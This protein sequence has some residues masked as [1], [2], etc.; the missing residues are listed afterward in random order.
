MHKKKIN[1]SNAPSV[2]LQSLD[3]TDPKIYVDFHKSLNKDFLI[4]PKLKT[5]LELSSQ[6]ILSLFPPVFFQSSNKYYLIARY[7][8]YSL[9][10]LERKYK[11]AAVIIDN[12]K[13]IPAVQQYEHIDKQ[14]LKK[15]SDLLNCAPTTTADTESKKNNTYRSRKSSSIAKSIKKGRICPYHKNDIFHVLTTP[16]K[17][18]LPDKNGLIA[19]QCINRSK[20][21]DFIGLVTPYELNLLEKYK[22][23]TNK[24]IE[25]VKD[26]LCPKCKKQPL[27][28]RTLLRDAKT[29]EEYVACRNN[30]S[31]S[32]HCDYFERTKQTS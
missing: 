10:L 1:D 15:M 8:V 31:I 18:S 25:E 7:W 22:Y 28:L 2:I 21:C 3:L 6:I 20:G 12:D 11:I 32:N 17:K 27:Y 24:W 16:R 29:V 26:S 4:S 13:L 19:I 5:V 9:Y 14:T 30:F 23:P